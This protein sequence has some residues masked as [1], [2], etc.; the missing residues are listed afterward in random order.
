LIPAGSRQENSAGGARA[1]DTFMATI[2]NGL[3]F[4]NQCCAEN[5]AK[6]PWKPFHVR[7]G[8]KPTESTVSIFRGWNVGTRG[9]GTA[10]GLLQRMRA[11]DSMG[12]YTFVADPLAAKT[13]KA[14]GWSDPD[15]LS[16]GLTE[17]AKT[18]FLRPEGINLVVVGGETNPI[19]HTTDYVYYKTASVDKWV[20]KAGIKLDKKPLRKLHRIR[21]GFKKRHPSVQEPYCCGRRMADTAAHL[22]DQVLQE[23]P[24]RQWVLSLPFALR[25]RLAYDSGLARDVL[26][27]FIR[28][29]FS[30]LR[31][32]AKKQS[33]IRKARCGGVTFVQRF[34]GALKLML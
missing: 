6:S 1:G 15:Q 21:G 22:V 3:S 13:L 9:L 8:F 32:R 27:I 11:F 20:P 7:T 18:P 33:G 12:A 25:Y 34:G 5:E 2:G 17:K 14:E 30:S 10:E 29:V 23:V 19:V 4:A 31:R 26:Q 28:T 16:K 24:I